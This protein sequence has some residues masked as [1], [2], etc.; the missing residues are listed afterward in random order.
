MFSELYI[1]YLEA[2]LKALYCIP[3]DFIHIIS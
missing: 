3:S 2:Y 1:A